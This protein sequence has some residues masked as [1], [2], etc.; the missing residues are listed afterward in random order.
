MS[1]IL[2]FEASKRR[3]FT[4]ETRVIKGLQVYFFGEDKDTTLNWGKRLII[5][6]IIVVIKYYDGLCYGLGCPPSQDFSGK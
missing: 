5:S 2:G 1:C 3:P 6:S 4:I